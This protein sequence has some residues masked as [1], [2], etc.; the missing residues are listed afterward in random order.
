MSSLDPYRECECE[1]KSWSES[2]KH[3][4]AAEEVH[5]LGGQKDK[6]LDFMKLDRM[7]ILG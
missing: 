5:I 3:T 2:A 7:F 4:F 6:A 1:A